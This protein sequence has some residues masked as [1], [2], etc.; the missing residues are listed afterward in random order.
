M[1]RVANAKLEVRDMEP[2]RR[3]P[4]KTREAQLAGFTAYIRRQLSHLAVQ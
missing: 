1:K 2:G 3:G 4:A